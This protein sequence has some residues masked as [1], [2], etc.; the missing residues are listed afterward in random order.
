MTNQ[1]DSEAMGG[2]A[3]RLSKEL[4]MDES[5]ITIV[6]D[7]DLA[8]YS[9]MGVGGIADCVAKP[10][11]KESL[12]A[13]L[14]LCLSSKI[15]YEISGCGS[16]TIFGD[17][18]G[19]LIDTKALKNILLL[20]Y[21]HNII[22]DRDAIKRL[23]ETIKNGEPVHIEVQ[24]G[25]PLH[26]RKGLATLAEEFSLSGLEYAIVIPGTIGGAAVMNAGVGTVETARIVEEVE[27][28]G[29]NGEPL[30]LSNE[31]LRYD[32]RYSKLQ[33]HYKGCV[34]YAV[35]LG[36]SKGSHDKISKATKERLEE[37]ANQP[38]GPSIGSM[39]RR[40]GNV[41]R[42]YGDKTSSVQYYT[43]EVI[44]EAGC[45]G[46]T[47]ENG[48]ARVPDEKDCISFIVGSKKKRLGGET[49]TYPSLYDVLELTKMVYDQVL[50]KRDVRLVLEGRFLGVTK[51]GNPLSNVVDELLAHTDQKYALGNL[52]YELGQ[53]E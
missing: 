15:P 29:P 22:K 34:V 19:V 28:I 16:N 12:Q 31:Q 35:R 3:E 6:P 36:L 40:R 10:V 11:T 42:R 43:D 20:Q 8:K 51:Q 41:M 1:P 46:W 9:T 27:L 44:W 50:A 32:H 2:I 47:S 18:H 13:L 48:K 21:A 33:D 17:I 14:R 53:S 23:T 52:R 30:R 5:Q 26:G 49:N 24:A 38:K 39:W 25:F 4:G 37:R 7:E 45:A